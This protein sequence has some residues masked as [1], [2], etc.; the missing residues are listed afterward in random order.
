VACEAP[1]AEKR[2]HVWC[3]PCAQP[4][5]LVAYNDGQDVKRWACRGCNWRH[6]IQHKSFFSGSHPSLKQIVLLMY[7]WAHDAPQT[8]MVHK[9]GTERAETIVDWCNLEA[10]LRKF[11]KPDQIEKLK[12]PHDHKGRGIVW[13]SET[14]QHCLTIRIQTLSFTPGIQ[15]DVLEWLEVKVSANDSQKLCV[16]L[17]HEMQLQSRIEFDKGLRHSRLRFAKDTAYIGKFE[18]YSGGQPAEIFEA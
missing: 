5:S 12:Q 3:M 17:I 18:I 16:L 10:N 14:M 1:T 15:Y 2:R 6:S 11:L 7:F 13:S 4:A 9:T 8:I